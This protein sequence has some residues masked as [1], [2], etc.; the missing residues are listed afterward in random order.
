MA[1]PPL[2]S[3]HLVHTSLPN[4]RAARQMADALIS[5]R[6]AACV[7]VWPVR[8]TYRWKGRLV[9]AREYLLEAKTARP[10]AAM[11]WI[12]K[13]HPHVLPMIYSLRASSAE[14]HFSRWIKGRSRSE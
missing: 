1:R 14:P 3:M 8:S 2:F 5:R 7:S 12:K 10:R 13:N 6:L 11:A 9:H 4:A